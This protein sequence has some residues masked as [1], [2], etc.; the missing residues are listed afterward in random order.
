MKTM[1]KVMSTVALT[2]MILGGAV[3]GTAQAASITATKP[4]ASSMVQDES[5]VVSDTQQGITL[6]V[7]KSLYDCNH[8]KV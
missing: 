2:G 4:Q 1:F 5:K 7:S 3:W 8:V 6:G